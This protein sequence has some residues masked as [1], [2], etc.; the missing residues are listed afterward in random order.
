MRRLFMDHAA[1]VDAYYLGHARVQ[2]RLLQIPSRAHV[3]SSA[4]LNARKH[5]GRKRKRQAELAAAGKFVAPPANLLRALTLVHADLS[6]DAAPCSTFEAHAPLTC[7]AS[8]D[9]RKPRALRVSPDALLANASDTVQLAAVRCETQLAFGD[10]GATP[11]DRDEQR[12]LLPPRCRFALG[13]VRRLQRYASALGRFQL[14]VMDPPWENKSVERGKQYTT[15]H[16]SE[17][18]KVDVPALADPDECVL[19]VWVTNRPQYTAFVLDTLLPRWGFQ[20]HDTWYWLKV[21]ANGDLVTP[22]A[23]THRLPFEKLLVAYR[24]ADPA[25]ASRLRARLGADPQ[26]VVSVPLRHSWKPP[27]ERFFRGA[28]DAGRSA[29]KLELFARELRPDWTSV[30]NEVL[31][32]QTTSLFDMCDDDATGSRAASSED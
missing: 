2:R 28:I 25:Q 13:D 31:K 9:W 16:H 18:L 7:V 30:G 19:G 27:P 10:D 20:L 4:A 24:S 15:F 26:V 12:V 22:L 1:L 5:A 29:R 8:D 17:L 3:A 6:T 32:F 23:S 21:C 11:S 14:I